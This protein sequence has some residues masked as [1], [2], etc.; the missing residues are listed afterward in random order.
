M[1]VLLVRALLA[2]LVIA[3]GSAFA[4]DISFT[5]INNTNEPIVRLWTSPT[6]NSKFFEATDV[7]VPK[8]GKSQDINF[9]E[10]ITGSDCYQDIMFQFQDGTRDTI[11]H[12]NLCS[13]KTIT[14]DV[15]DAGEVTY[16]TQN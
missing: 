13:I 4:Y 1:R 16:S 5:M 2:I 15:N 14:I 6:T 8:G 7:Y 9:D 3:P 12:V 10:N 11:D